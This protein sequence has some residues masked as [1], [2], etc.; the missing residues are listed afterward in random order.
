MSIDR[1]KSR[2]VPLTG[3][4]VHVHHL[5]RA[6]GID[7]WPQLMRQPN[8][9]EIL[10]SVASP[11][12]IHAKHLLEGGPYTWSELVCNIV[13]IGSELWGSPTEREVSIREH[14]REL[15]HEWLE[16]GCWIEP[17]SDQA[18][19]LRAQVAELAGA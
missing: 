10:L 19:R 14:L 6:T 5:Q 1:G 18:V 4:A 3:Y 11:I 9:L 12:D 7:D 13:G 2:P 15:V 16:Y 17:E 8:R